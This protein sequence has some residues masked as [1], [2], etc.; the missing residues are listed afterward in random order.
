MY[1][2][3]TV[4]REHAEQALQKCKRLIDAGGYYCHCSLEFVHWEAC[5]CLPH[6]WFLPDLEMTKQIRIGRIN[7]AGKLKDETAAKAVASRYGIARHHV[8]ES[9]AWIKER[10][11]LDYA[12]LTDAI[13]RLPTSQKCERLAEAFSIMSPSDKRELA[14]RLIPQSWIVNERRF[15]LSAGWIT[16][17]FMCLISVLMG[18]YSYL[19]CTGAAPGEER[20]EHDYQDMEYVLLLSRADAI[21]TRD[22]GLTNLAH[23]A[24]PEKDVFSN[25]ND[26][27]KSYRCN[28]AG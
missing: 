23:A 8:L 10:L 19:R 5:H 9:S 18:E 26:V 28:W 21:I 11:E 12:D 14:L 22:K 7:V 13:R 17:Q 4:D 6:P 3:G 2:C 1:E 24:F 27:P 25:L 20:A 16:W 15:F